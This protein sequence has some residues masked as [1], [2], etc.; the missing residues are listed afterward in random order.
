[1][2]L[3]VQKIVFGAE[4]SSFGLSER[5]VLEIAGKVVR[6][7]TKDSAHDWVLSDVECKK[8]NVVLI[9]LEVSRSLEMY[10]AKEMIPELREDARR[11]FDKIE[12]VL[13][14][15]T[16]VKQFI[17]VYNNCNS[18]NDEKSEDAKEI[19]RKVGIPVIS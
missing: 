16:Y 14:D 5:E 19:M 15:Y 17:T 8:N 11:I 3:W 6:T 7:V 18:H 10:S 9:S 12:Q 1:M 13:G 4:I 2:R